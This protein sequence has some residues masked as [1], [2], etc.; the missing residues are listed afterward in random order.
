MTIIQKNMTQPKAGAT[1]YV[2]D[3]SSKKSAQRVFLK[4][5][6]PQRKYSPSV[7]YSC[8]K[9][10]LSADVSAIVDLLLEIE[11]DLRGP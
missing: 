3:R 9:R 1:N 11:F 2:P 10:Q 8:K 5:H 6:S 4:I 7:K